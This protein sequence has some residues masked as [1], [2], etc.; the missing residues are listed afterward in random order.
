MGETKIANFKDDAQLRAVLSSDK[1]R[2]QIDNFFG[3]NQKALE[4]YSNVFAEVQ[5][6]PKLRECT[7]PSVINAFI[8]MASLKLMPSGVSGEAYVIPYKNQGVM[9]AQFQLGYQGIVT[10]LYGAGA[11]S[12]TSEIVRKNDI[13]RIV[14]GKVHHEI[15]PFKTRQ[16]RGDAMGSYAIIVTQNGGTVEKFMRMDEI[17]KH[18]ARFSKSFNSDFSPWKANNDPEGWMPR[19]TVLKQ[20]AK[21]APKNERLFRAL[22]EDNKD[23]TVSDA[24]LEAAKVASE[25]IKMGNLQTHD[26]T[27]EDKKNK[28]KDE[29]NETPESDEDKGT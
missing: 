18:A 25:D 28:E 6:N 26:N 11:K 20:A 24:R 1:Y 10:L 8:T 19:K 14:N 17:L 9:E 3:D 29:A 27:N 7:A 13:F 21:L 12:I 5:R 15:D 23:S 16:E 22:D 2:K 4:F